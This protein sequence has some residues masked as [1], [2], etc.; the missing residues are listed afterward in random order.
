MEKG[1]CYIFGAGEHAAWELPPL[2]EGDFV[3]A[4]DGGYP[5]AL[6]AFSRVHLAVG[7]FD[8][9]GYRPEG[10]EL[11]AYPPEKDDT[12]LALACRAAVARGY[13]RLLILG[14]LGGRLDHSLANLQLL[15]ALAGEGVDATLLGA[16]GVAALVLTGGECLSFPA[17]SR[18]RLS[19]LAIGGNATGVS[20]S[21]VKY[22]LSGGTLL[23]TYPLGVSNE[24]LGGAAAV[25]L[26]AGRLLVLFPAALLGDLCREGI[27]SKE[28]LTG[29]PI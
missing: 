27:E 25:S 3:I 16:D 8:S 5:T 14:G 9:L 29:G 24:L 19:V 22:P 28:N 12:D 6:G 17:G 11:L 15:S 26:T 23:A 4:A 20:L 2:G 7:D 21:G 10:V 18:G 1:I 13:T